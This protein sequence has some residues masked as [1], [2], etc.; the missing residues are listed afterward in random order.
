V[1]PG[2]NIATEAVVKAAPDGYTLLVITAANADSRLIG[3]TGVISR[4]RLKLSLS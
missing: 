3:P 2:S 4:I 1:A